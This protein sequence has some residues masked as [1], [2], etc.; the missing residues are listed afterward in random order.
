MRKG[1]CGLC[2]LGLGCKEFML[3]MKG[4]QKGQAT[5]WQDLPVAANLVISRMRRRALVP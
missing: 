3:Q 1:S 4:K 5:R 2:S